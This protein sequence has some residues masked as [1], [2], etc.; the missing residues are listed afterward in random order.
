ML[1]VLLALRRAA[2]AVGLVLAT[3]SSAAAPPAIKILTLDW[4]SQVV[5]SHIFGDLLERLGHEVVYV[6]DAAEAQWFLLSSGQADLQVEVWE[7]TMAE[8]LTE[9][10]G[11]GLIV[12]AGSHAALT[13]EEWWFPDYVRP[14]CPGLPDW[15]ALKRCPEIFSPDGGGR[16]VYYTGPWE[17]PDAARIRAL[18]LAFD[19]VHLPDAAA[20]HRVL[21]DAANAAR[22]VVL[23]N[24]TPNWVESIY[25]G[26]F[27]EFPAYDPACETNPGWGPNPELSWDCGNPKDG[28]LKK[29][30]SR[31]FASR[32]P[33]AYD[34]VRRASFDNEDI[35]R[36]AALVDV[37]GMTAVDAARFWLDTR[38]HIWQPWLAA[39]GC[40]ATAPVER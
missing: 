9:L 11:R 37:E 21:R 34:L 13:R 26:A 14:L 1:A 40:T 39:A 27:V 19:V 28:W 6:E 25:P 33:C 4:T 2:V 36:A 7:G 10:S 24:W 22:P 31:D 38:P 20:L 5:L 30:V 3:V 17:K 18:G 29:A 23:F 16:G 8:K 32:W 15:R 12:D 35:A